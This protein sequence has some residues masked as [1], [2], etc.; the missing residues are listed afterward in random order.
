MD[1]SNIDIKIL[2]AYNQEES[3]SPTLSKDEQQKF[4]LR[5]YKE[6]VKGA[7]M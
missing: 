3:L 4:M 2:E 1:T 5:K 6:L 7:A